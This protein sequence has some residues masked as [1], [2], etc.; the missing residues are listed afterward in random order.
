MQG[1]K[2]KVF[3]L[4]YLIVVLVNL[5]SHGF[6]LPLLELISK[7]LLMPLLALFVIVNI[8]GTLSS[9]KW[10]LFGALFFSWIGDVAL[11][12][13]EKY[14]ILFMVGLGGFLLAHINYILLFFKSAG[15][16]NI[17]KVGTLLLVAVIILYT[18]YLIQLLWP[19]LDELKIPVVVYALV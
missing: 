16:F 19:H 8:S 4:S 5:L 11:L 14:P 12:F 2:G 13:D 18:G 17:T 9:L 6:S 15:R 10:F 1:L 3:F 7:P